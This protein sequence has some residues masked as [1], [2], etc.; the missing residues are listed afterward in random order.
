MAKQ[1]LDRCAKLRTEMLDENKDSIENIIVIGIELTDTGSP[2]G[3]LIQSKCNP[4]MAL[5]ILER[6]E[7]EIENLKKEI[8]NKIDDLSDM[9]DDHGSFAQGLKDM[10][11]SIGGQTFEATDNDIDTLK[12]LRD[13]MKDAADN[14]DSAEAERVRNE[15][16]EF[17]RKRFGLNNGSASSDFN[18][19]DF[20]G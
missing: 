3:V 10:M 9:N 16:K 6:M 15:L 7:R 4:F 19:N 11:S 13:R 8:H 1:Y 18:P 5:G 2:K 14:R 17:M 12:A 20:M